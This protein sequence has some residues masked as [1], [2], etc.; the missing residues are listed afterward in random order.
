MLS[1]LI[2]QNFENPAHLPILNPEHPLHQTETPP[3]LLAIGHDMNH[4]VS[5]DRGIARRDQIALPLNQRMK[6]DGPLRF[7]PSAGQT[8]LIQLVQ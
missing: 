4:I 2:G 5:I 6:P 1:D 3:L 8:G 7:T